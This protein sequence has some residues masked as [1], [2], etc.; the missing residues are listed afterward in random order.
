MDKEV[1]TQDN[2][3]RS[4]KK[5]VLIT[6]AAFL[7][8]YILLQILPYRGFS[9]ESNFKIEDGEA[10]LVISHGGAKHLY[11]ENT[12]MAFEES[13]EMGVDVLEMDLCM[14]ADGMLVTHHDLTV[15][16]TANA[17]G[18]V[19][20]YTYEQLLSM[21]FGYNF[22]DL[23]GDLPYRD[24]TDTETLSRLVPMTVEEMF[25]Q[26]GDDALYVMEI[27]DGEEVGFAAA[28][29]LNRLI[30]EYELWEYVCV[31]SF[32]SEVMDHFVEIK[33]DRVN[34]SM[35]MSSATTFV[36]ANYAGFGIFFEFPHAGLQLPPSMSGIPLDNSYL[37]YKIHHNNM[38]L[39]Y[40]TINDKEEMRRLIELG[41]DGIITDR[42]DLMIELLAE[43][44]Y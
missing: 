40:W 8:I 1:K 2:K 15:D 23:D 14:T 9:G 25:S 3:K 36:V 21:N 11:P 24:E 5:I 42:P 26:F 38:F 27:K 39:H 31:A 10:P 32:H 17:T 18:E 35:D 13:F 41:C 16:A 20:D 29:E 19:N 44:G 12:V 37:E 30:D 43:M 33:D 7:V 6:L 4:K 28:E 34:I 22:E